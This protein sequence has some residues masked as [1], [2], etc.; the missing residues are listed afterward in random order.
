[1]HHLQP[2]STTETK[3]SLYCDMFFERCSSRA[4]TCSNVI[5]CATNQRRLQE[6][7]AAGAL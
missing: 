4:L 3:N 1:M 7:T 5:C 2:T 6:L